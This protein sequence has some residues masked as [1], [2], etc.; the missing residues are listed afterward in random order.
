MLK[1]SGHYTQRW[2][3]ALHLALVVALICGVLGSTGPQSALAS[4]P[5]GDVIYNYPYT[6]APTTTSESPRDIDWSTIVDHND[7]TVMRPGSVDASGLGG[8]P[9]QAFEQAYT[10]YL[11]GYYN[12][13]ATPDHLVMT[14]TAVSFYGYGIA[15]YMDYSFTSGNS[16]TQ[17]GLSFVMNPAKM[18]FHTLSETG[19]LFNG[20][21]EKGA[22]DNTYYTGYALILACANESGMQEKNPD[23]PNTASLCL[24][25][26]NHERWDTE[27][28][29]PGNTTTTRTLVATIKT[30]IKDEST[31]SYR[32]SVEIDPT[33]RAFK[34]FVDNACWA[35]VSATQVQGP[36]AATG[37]G[38]YTGYY[39]HNCSMLTVIRYEDISVI[40]GTDATPPAPANCQVKFV[41]DGSPETELRVPETEVGF[42]NQGYRIVQPQKIKMGDETYYLM[43]NSLGGSTRNDIRL[44]YDKDPSK[45]VTILYYALP[46]DLSTKA[47]EKDARV[48]GGDWNNG[49]E[50]EPVPV[51]SGDTIEYA[52]TAY[53]PP[54]AVP[55][56]R[57]GNTGSDADSTWWG[58]SAGSPTIQKDQVATVTF[59]DLPNYLMPS[60]AVTQFLD[61]YPTWDGK[62]VLKAW[63]ATETGAVNPDSG[64]QRV[65]VWATQSAI[66]G[67]YDLF[68]GGQ[69]GVWMSAS[70]SGS[71]LFY[72]FRNATSIDLAN[73]HTDRAQSMSY[74]FSYFG[75][76]STTPPELDLSSFD[77]AKVT[78][79][80]NMFAYF[81]YN[82]TAPPVLDLSHFD[83]AKVTNMS[84]MFYYCDYNSLTAPVLDLSHFDTSNVTDMSSMFSNF[85][86]KSMT[87]PVL[88]MTHFNTAKV[89]S[90]SG[91][92]SYFCASSTA[93]PELDLTHFDTSNVTNMSGMFNYCAS[94]T[95]M[96]VGLDLTHFNTAKVT[97][98]SNM[99]NSFGL[100][101][102]TPP[103]LDLT[104]FDTG[105]VTNMGYMFSNLGYSS[106]TPPSLILTNF[107]T[108]KVQNMTYMFSS[109][110]Y[111]A[112]TPPELD[113][114]H[115][116]TSQVTDMSN[117]FTTYSSNSLTPP[118]LD[119]TR[120]DTA[121]VTNMSSMF[122][123]YSYRSLAPPVLD[124]SHFNTASVTNMS[125]MFSYFVYSS[126]T[127]PALDLSH[128]DTAKVTSMS[129]MFNRFSYNSTTAP[130][131]DLSHFNTSQVT[132]MNS[133]FAYFAHAALTLPDLDLSRF[134]TSKVT[135]M[136]NMFD[137]YS[138]TAPS[139]TLD[140]EWFKIGAA[141][142]GTTVASM[143]ANCPRLTVLHLESGVFSSATILN[144][145][146]MFAS[147]TAGLDVRVATVSDQAWMLA[148]SPTPSSVTVVGTPSGTQ[149]APVPVVAPVLIAP[150]PP[151]T[152]VLKDPL[153][154][155]LDP[156][157]PL[158]GS[159]GSRYTTITDTIPD[160]L[161]IIPTSITGT[162][163]STVAT[164]TITWQ[165]NEQT[166][167]WK[168]PESM[169]PAEVS[170]K[171]TVDKIST[172]LPAGTLFK[173]VAY[174][175]D[176]VTNPTFHEFSRDW[177]AIERYV[178]YDG[179]TNSIKLDNDLDTMV[180][181]GE[182][183]L[184]QQPRT[185]LNGYSYYG[186]QRIGVD[187][188]VV[189]G[190]APPSTAVFPPHSDDFDTTHTETVVLY[191]V[192][193]TPTV[194]V[195]FVNESGQE[196]KAPVVAAVNLHQDYYLL[197]SYFASFSDGSNSWTYYN[198]AKNIDLTV[199]DQG[200]P[201]PAL[202][203]GVA[204]VYPN[205]SAP[206]F[207][208]AQ[209]TAD[210]EVTLYFTTQKA[211]TVHFVEEGNPSHILHPDETYFVMPT[212]DADS[213]LRT[214]DSELLTST[215]IDPVTGKPYTYVSK[216]SKDCGTTITAGSPGV[217]DTPADITLYFGTAYTVTEKF[218]TNC[219]NAED[220]PVT[221]AA[222][223]VFSDIAGG[224]SFYVNNLEGSKPPAKIGKY[225]Y[226]G[227]RVGNSSNPLILGYPDP[228][229]PLIDSVNR[230]E[231][232]IYIYDLPGTDFNF[233]KQNRDGTALEG[234]VFRLTPQDEEGNW[235]STEAT[236]VASN[237]DGLVSFKTLPDNTYLL[238]ET[239]TLPGYALPAGQW[240]VTIAAAADP[241][242]AITT[243]GSPMAFSHD[244][245]GDL[246]LINYQ[247]QKLPFSGGLGVIATTAGGVALVV[248]AF[249]LFIEQ[250]RTRVPSACREHPSLRIT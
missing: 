170:V 44:A 187:P 196:I 34:V 101:S 204:L 164:E 155:V 42:V 83:T 103:E 174:V 206:T 45:N 70:T 66:P 222:D 190:A 65:V 94:A 224:D 213:A 2:K 27:N 232:I 111:G 201:A 236:T 124:L 87:A 29:S 90:M 186:Y 19:Y 219:A 229:T 102:Q 130:Y 165:V 157:I 161:T 11:S 182:S 234:V 8:V 72:Y 215:L 227:Y 249:W 158:E 51:V 121:Q 116:D 49:S 16:S 10:P 199:A 148:L 137:N 139:F 12:G 179:D 91:M 95:L 36:S 86:N 122:N 9:L 76:N 100:K 198:Y 74:L 97:N 15:P 162:E 108:S 138:Y 93:P 109:Y 98:M 13:V 153:P 193:T 39:A 50:D 136:S 75:Y 231:T 58:Q 192:K 68:V 113:L 214:D 146:N 55:M 212:F 126:T 56:M 52:I 210:K 241:A 145:A 195:H 3:R 163:S 89:T 152:P 123:S 141:S 220:T 168:I 177:R 235:D 54:T 119:L 245:K 243:I 25:Y 60:I 85:A 21:M 205:P 115:F 82:S 183:Y 176:E 223:N 237:A 142:G 191:Y 211:V 230:D 203:P 209:M 57:Q 120:F 22:D 134:D 169:L 129:N 67:R 117:M 99:F 200:M 6:P 218:Q 69:G 194:T 24:Y 197:N 18:F 244:D 228:D 181:E 4:E 233:T 64:V 131:L 1:R 167:I 47:P 240:V 159:T 40:T 226:I 150:L 80:S 239:R 216:Y 31:A 92:F 5:V 160:G 128:F 185:T 248:L 250:K 127:A 84:A 104:H 88:D 37:F 125:S 114:T 38:F 26:I 79:M 144:P 151:G 180:A 247:T 217:V 106:A 41:V 242:V 73:F 107:D 238:E 202:S 96:T 112:T 59:V 30:G 143:F 208:A 225:S 81:G 71:Y 17:Q 172:D 132:N 110:A 178:I 171:V 207:T 53:A 61:T 14:D 118:V 135:D 173:N 28:F 188:G 62:E 35:T 7:P 147:A 63:D 149:P 133:M 78:N 221:L 77:T 184:I 189:T 23:A 20:Q 105:N 156:P 175:G 33:T 246:I 48:N 46:S 32:V 154:V 140:L 166:I 43:R